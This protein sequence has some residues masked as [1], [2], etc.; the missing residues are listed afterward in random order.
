MGS[1]KTVFIAADPPMP[2]TGGGT[3]AFHFGKI[4]NDIV[5]CHLYILFSV[6][7]ETLPQIILNNCISVRIATVE[8]TSSNISKACILFNYLRL[9]FAPWSFSKK[10]LILAA[11][12][13]ATNPYPGKQL[14]KQGFFLLLRYSITWYAVMLYRMGYS[15]P[16]KSLERVE[17]FKELKKEINKDIEI[18][19]LL[20]LDFST[21]FTFFSNSRKANPSLRIFCNAHNI[22][23]RVL[24]RMRNLAKDKLE[25]NWL[26]CQA[27][28][29]K[30]AE[31]EGFSYCDLVIT[32]SEQDKQVI[33][34]NLP[35][36]NVEVIPNGV[37]INYFIPESFPT[38]HPSLIFTGNMGYKPNQDAVYYFIEKIFPYV[39]G[40]N[41]S[42][43]F[44]IAGARAGEVFEKYQNWSNIEII[45]SPVDMRPIYNKAWIAVVPLRIGGGTRLKILEAMAMEKPVVTTSIGAEGLVFKDN[46]QIF[47]ADD[48]L[49]FAARINMLI[50]DRNIAANMVKAAKETVCQVYDWERIRKNIANTIQKMLDFNFSKTVL[51]DIK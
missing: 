29:M 5:D 40:A 43:T 23:Y 41:P 31:L 46:H 24:E 33:L 51:P 7:R 49:D 27:A 45:S 28:V 10:D 17:Q 3:R 44:I 30:S 13:H 22:E 37:D 20:W 6:K 2:K 25:K 11:D 48:E 8:F 18:S 47:I 50:R 36:A 1:L 39:M 15:I 32:C 4:L 35:N 38:E 16:A 14:L 12:Y 34:L 21:L 9:L 19:Q 42:C 26:T